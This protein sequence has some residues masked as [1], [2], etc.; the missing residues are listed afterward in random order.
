MRIL[1]V[2]NSLDGGGAALPLPDVIGLMR[3]AGHD[4]SVVSLM[5]RDGRARPALDRAGIPY[6]VVGGARR[7]FVRPGVH[8]RRIVRAESPDLLWTSLSHATILGQIV[9]RME[10]VPVVSWLHNAFLKPANQAI[11]RRT[12]RWTRHWVS[13]SPEVI[14]FGEAALGISRGDITLWPLFIADPAAPRAHP[15]RHDGPV[16]IG[17]LGRLHPNKGYDTLIDALALLPP[18]TCAAIEVVIGGEGDQFAPLTAHAARL[19]VDNI[20]FA[21]FQT[22][23]RAFLAGLDAYVQ[24]S[25]HEGLCIAAHEAMQAGLPVI[26]T[27]VGEIQRSCALSCGGALFAYGDRPA[28]AD[29]LATTVSERD[30]WRL[31]GAAAREWVLDTYSREKFDARGRAALAAAGVV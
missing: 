24:P 3:G 27:H 19:G 12:R 14:D 29:I 16:R 26:S 20:R 10:R 9:G 30:R 5:E 25:H 1:Y 2:I 11:M 13:D 17:S 31:A 21:G 28:L 22:D 15:F 4:V 7:D 6:R 8:L 23:P 18:A